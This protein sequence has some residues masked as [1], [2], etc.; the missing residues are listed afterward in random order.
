MASTTS[1]SERSSRTTLRS[2]RL[3]LCAAEDAR[4]MPR[5]MTLTTTSFSEW[6]GVH[7]KALTRSLMGR[8]HIHVASYLQD[9]SADSAAGQAAIPGLTRRDVMDLATTHEQVT[10]LFADVVGFT[11]MSEHIP[12]H[13]VLL[14]INHLFCIFDGL[15]DQHDV[16]K[17]DTV[18]DCYFAVGGLFGEEP[19]TPQAG[20]Q[21]SPKCNPLRLGGHANSPLLHT[22]TDADTESS[23][24]SPVTG[25]RITNRWTTQRY[26][27]S[28]SQKHA[29]D[30]CERRLGGRDPHQVT[31]VVAFAKEMLARSRTEVMPHGSPVQLRIGIHTGS[32]VSGLVGQRMPRF[33]LFGDTVNTASRIETLGVPNC[34]HVSQAVREL[35]PEESWIDRGG[36]SAKGKKK[37]LH[38]FLL[39]E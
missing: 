23:T 13:E 8:H 6:T 21:S 36:V 14:F 25:P 7:T 12:A 4:E 24:G 3:P 16:H 30:P 37:R 5:R 20:I 10:V 27:G 2:G 38:T 1:R 17:V 32:C 11:S 34:I 31:K 15:L 28:G 22:C 35:C 39:A 19:A 33:T 9:F 26:S 18:G 29:H